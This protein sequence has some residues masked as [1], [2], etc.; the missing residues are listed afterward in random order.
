MSFNLRSS[1]TEC[2][3]FGT[4]QPLSV[5][6]LPTYEDIMKH[7]LFITNEM[8]KTCKKSPSMKL[9]RG[10]IVKNVVE[11]WAKASIPTVSVQRVESMFST[12]Y[13]KYKN[14]KKSFG[15]KAHTTENNKDKSKTAL[16]EMAQQLFDIAACKCPEPKFCKCPTFKKIPFLELKF[17]EDQR[18]VR[19][20]G[21]GGVDQKETKNMRDKEERKIK[22]IARSKS[23]QTIKNIQGE[24]T[25]FFSPES[26][27][28]QDSDSETDEWCP[29]KRSLSLE[30]S[31]YNCKK[32]K[33]ASVAADRFVVSSG[34]AAAIISGALQDYKLV[35]GSDSSLLVD[36][37]KLNRQRSKIRTEKREEASI[38]LQTNTVTAIYFDGKKDETKTV[39]K[40]GNKSRTI[41][42]IE[43]HISVLSQ[44]NDE[45]LTHLTPAGGTGEQIASVLFE[46]L[47]NLPALDLR[48]VGCDGTNVNTGWKA[49]AI[50]LLEKKLGYPVQRFICLLHGNELP[51]RHM[52]QNIDGSTTGPTSFSG[53]IGKSLVR[54]LSLQVV[55]FKKIDVEI[56]NFDSKLLSTDQKYLIDIAH[57]IKSG[58]C[59]DNLASRDPGPLNHSRWVTTGNRLMRVYIGTMNPSVELV[60]LVE[61]VMKVY[62]PMWFTI[63]KEPSCTNGSRHMMK[64]ITLSSYLPTKYK[65]IVQQVIQQNAYFL[66]PENVLICMVTDNDPEIRKRGLELVLLSRETAKKEGKIRPFRVPKINFEAT[67]YSDLISWD[68]IDLTTPPAMNNFSTSELAD[69]FNQNEVPQ[70]P[71]LDYPCHTQSVERIVQEVSKAS[72]MVCGF[73]A[74]DGLIL[75][76]ISHRKLMPS[77][78]TKADYKISTEEKSI[79]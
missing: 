35:T 63:R 77:L 46:Y 52:F 3:I 57:A 61:F 68:E 78:R 12:F 8:K 58:L 39:D 18:T 50:A 55:Q 1:D 38:S 29:Q 36:K 26:E 20:M 79:V 33:N 24:S 65:V 27:S 72:K 31:Y 41:S 21:V 60:T 44:P 53:P 9:I 16:L 67:H 54:C 49:G 45:Y 74:R 76:K 28:G 43:E 66:H 59:P 56:P 11:I 19:K 73:E 7:F 23:L 4:P 10:K 42:K 13:E 25:S 37:S 2:P 5:V 62:V 70:L 48:A 51:L 71:I 30:S 47:Q 75:S 15:S 22:R 69:Y 64:Q 34:S 14:A 32:L 6:M 17:M 40:T